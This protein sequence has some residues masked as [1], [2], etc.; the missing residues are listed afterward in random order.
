MENYVRY[1]VYTPAWG[2]FN[3][4]SLGSNPRGLPSSGSAGAIYFLGLKIISPR[5]IKNKNDY[6]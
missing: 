3:G 5:K 6:E 2:N 4:S 1:F